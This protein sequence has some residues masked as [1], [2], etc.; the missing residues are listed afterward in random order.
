MHVQV[1]IVGAG[2]AG[3]LLSRL[4]HL[5]GISSVILEDRSRAYCESR[6]RAG[7]IEQGSV[8]LLIAAGVGERMLHE[9]SATGTRCVLRHSHRIDFLELTGKRIT[10]Y[11]QQEIV[12]DMIAVNLAAGG[13][14]EFDVTDV[15]LHDIASERP[16]IRYRDAGGAPAELVCDFIAGCDGFHGVSRPAIPAGVLTAFERAYPFSWLGILTESP[17]LS[18][19]LLYVCHERG[20]A[21]FTMRSTT[22]SRL[23]LQVGADEELETLT[24]DAED[25]L[26]QLELPYRTVLLCAG[27]MGFSAAKTYDIEV[28]LPSQKTYREI[29]SCSNTE[30]FQARRAN[31]KFRASGSGKAEFVHTLNGSGLAVGRTLIAILENNQQKDGSVTIPTAL[32][33]YMDGRAAIE[34]KV[35]VR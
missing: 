7:L 27:D 35:A 25:I 23:Y 5:A 11:G 34:P 32:R 8:D 3:L 31:I 2:P 13:R 28:W 6:V 4:L 15:S 17:P 18:P 19:E 14:I 30:A 24:A 16:R 12:K 21:L 22:I 9:G 26:K 10:I 20:F 33:P 1:G 29:S